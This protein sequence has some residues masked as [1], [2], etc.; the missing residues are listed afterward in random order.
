[1]SSSLSAGKSFQLWEESDHAPVQEYRPQGLRSLTSLH[2]VCVVQKLMTWLVGKETKATV[3]IYI[4]IYIQLI[5][6]QTDGDKSWAK[7][8]FFE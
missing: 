8:A 5:Q 4:Y 2:R 3:Y 1:M 7:K 6:K